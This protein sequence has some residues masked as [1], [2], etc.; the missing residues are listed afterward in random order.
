[1]RKVWRLSTTPDE[2]DSIIREIEHYISSEQ[3]H[4]KCLIQMQSNLETE[5]QRLLDQDPYQG[6]SEASLNEIQIPTPESL[7]DLSR[8]ALD[9]HALSIAFTRYLNVKQ[10]KQKVMF[11]VLLTDLLCEITFQ[12]GERQL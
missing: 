10:W 4:S 12:T 11:N 6:D 3:D 8:F 9:I 5:L 1:M 7:F 2:L